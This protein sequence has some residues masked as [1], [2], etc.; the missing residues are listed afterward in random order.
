MIAHSS[1]SRSNMA[2]KQ[3]LKRLADGEFHSGQALADEWGVSR[4]AVWKQVESLTGVGLDVERV[5]GKGYRLKGGLELLDQGLITA[6]LDAP[7]RAQLCELQ[8]LDHTDSTNA[9]LQ[10]DSA[11]MAGARVCLAEYQSAGRGR[12]GRQWLSPYGSNIYCSVAW[13]F[14]GG[15]EVLEGLSLAVGVILCDALMACGVE[16]LALKW[17]NDLLLQGRKL[18][19][20]LVEVQGDLDGPVTAI[21][22]VGVNVRM[23]ESIRGG[24]DQPWSD[25]SNESGASRNRV[26]GRYLNGL[27]PALANYEAGGFEPWHSRWL[28]LDAYADAPVMVHS[29]NQRTAGIARGV[30]GRGALR[31]ETGAG[32]ETL[33]GGEVSL[34]PAP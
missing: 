6:E 9:E 26:I 4:T 2:T 18:A 8:L 33:Y 13:T 17:P 16:G 31:L 21:I 10:R 15:A 5:R 19:G 20:V 23:P 29:G 22:G 27:L 7:A 28:A 1:S 12:R 25:L 32:I 34:R 11:P 30:D 24:I 3:V 14:E